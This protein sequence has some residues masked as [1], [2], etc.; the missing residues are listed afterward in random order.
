MCESLN[1]YFFY[2]IWLNSDESITHRFFL[3]KIIISCILP[4]VSKRGRSGF[5]GMSEVLTARGG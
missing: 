1:D 3:N 5:D 4:L 2:L